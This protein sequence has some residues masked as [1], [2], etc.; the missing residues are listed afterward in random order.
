MTIPEPTDGRASKGEYLQ[1]LGHARGS[2]F[3]VQTQLVIAKE[4]G[5]GAAETR[6]RSEQLAQEVGRM[7][8][9]MMNSLPHS[10]RSNP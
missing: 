1:F 3:E 7:L 6:Q 8:V 10:T 4:L 5:F 2:N 9:A